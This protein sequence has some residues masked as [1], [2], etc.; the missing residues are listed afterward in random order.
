M[1]SQAQTAQT[2]KAACRNP[3]IRR[4]LAEV[5]RDLDTRLLE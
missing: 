3:D 1:L 4:M 5:V 2:S